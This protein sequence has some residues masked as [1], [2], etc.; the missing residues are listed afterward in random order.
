[1]SDMGEPSRRERHLKVDCGWTQPKDGNGDGIG[2]LQCTIDPRAHL[3]YPQLRLIHEPAEGSP[4][5]ASDLGK[6]RVLRFSTAES[7]MSGF[8]RSPARRGCE[9][10]PRNPSAHGRAPA[11]REGTNEDPRLPSL[12]WAPIAQGQR[13]PAGMKWKVLGEKRPRQIAGSAKESAFDHE[14]VRGGR[15][16]YAPS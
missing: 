5:R 2:S 1:M 8:A 10:C 15:L 9:P 12:V 11:H 7:G 13:C 6:R 3:P 4:S 14:L 16:G